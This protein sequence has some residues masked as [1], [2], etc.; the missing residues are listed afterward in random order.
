[1]HFVTVQLSWF[2]VYKY[3]CPDSRVLCFALRSGQ[4]DWVSIQDSPSALELSLKIQPSILF[5]Y[6]VVQWCIWFVPDV[7]CYSSVVS[8]LTLMYLIFYTVASW[9]TISFSSAAF[10]YTLCLWSEIFIYCIFWGLSNFYLQRGI[11]RNSIPTCVSTYTLIMDVNGWKY[12]IVIVGI[13]ALVALGKTQHMEWMYLQ[14]HFHSSLN[15]SLLTRFLWILEHS[16]R[17]QNPFVSLTIHLLL[18]LEYSITPLR[19][20]FLV[21]RWSRQFQIEL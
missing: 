7:S 21:S 12:L 1:M 16:L 19:M 4:I 10:S 18:T 14:N 2:T 17:F 20:I 3:L 6:P 13:R 5:Q 8:Y 11:L 9:T 15:L